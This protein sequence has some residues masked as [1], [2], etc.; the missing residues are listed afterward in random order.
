MNTIEY[1]KQTYSYAE[2]IFLKDIRIGRKSKT[3]IRKDLSRATKRGEIFRESPGIYYFVNKEE[4]IVREVSFEDIIVKKYIKE[5][6]GFT[7][8]DI[9]VYG[10]YS[11]LT[12]FHQLD[13]TTQVPAVIEVTTNYTSCT[14]E[15]NISGRRA[16]IKKGKTKITPQ[17]W[18]IL[19]FLDLIAYLDEK[20]IKNNLVF[21]INYALNNLTKQDLDDHIQFYGIKTQ[22]LL[23]EGGLINAFIPRPGVI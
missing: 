20:T 15:I 6:Y 21:L 18:K 7:G 5:D 13:L 2:P 3:A 22:K 1:L 12:F 19:Q 8:L 9:E 11:G 17:N 14:R 16:I 10:Y 4:R 23:K